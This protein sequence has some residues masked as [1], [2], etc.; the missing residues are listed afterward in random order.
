LY[1]PDVKVAIKKF[2]A[3]QERKEQ[4]MAQQQQ[5]LSAQQSEQ[6]VVEKEAEV[7]SQLTIDKGRSEN[8]AQLMEMKEMLKQST[9]EQNNAFKS[10]MESQRAEMQILLEAIKEQKGS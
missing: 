4:M 10:M 2:M 3:L 9:N 7:Q 5:A 6:N 8:K 1:E